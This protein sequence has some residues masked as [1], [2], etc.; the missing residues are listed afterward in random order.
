MIANDWARRMKNRITPFA[1]IGVIRGQF[2]PSASVIIAPLIGRGIDDSERSLAVGCMSGCSRWLI[3]LG[4]WACVA[5]GLSPAAEETRP[6]WPRP[7]APASSPVSPED[8]LKFFQLDPA[9][10]IELAAAEPQVIDP[11]AVR[12]DEDGRM[13]V[14]EM[15]DYPHGPVKGEPGKSQIKVLEDRDG[16]GRYET[17]TVFAD[18]LTFVTGLQPWKGGVFVT[19][20]GRVAYMKDTDG[21]G[22]ADLDETWFTGFA[23]ENS[24]LRANHPR[25]ALD[26]HIYVANGLRGGKVVNVRKKETK[27]IDISGMDFRFNPLT[28]D[29]EA[30]SG[31]S[32]FGLT[33]D[34]YGNRF[35]CTNRN[36]LV[37]V[38]LEQ[39]YL[40]QNPAV[41]VPSVV[42]D[43]AAAGE[44]SRLFPLTRNWTTSNL[45]AGQFTAAC[46]VEIYRGDALPKEFYGNAFTCDPTANL[47]HREIISPHGATFKSRPAYPDR[48]FLAST[49]E[50]FRPVN[51]TLGPEG[52]LYVVD[53]YRAVIEHPEFVPD[54]L[55]KRPDLMLGNDRGRIYRIVAKQASDRREPA[56]KQRPQ[57]SKAKSE[58]LVKLLEHE[59]AW[60]RETAQRLLVQRQDN[61][62]E[63]LLKQAMRMSQW[64]LAQIHAL[65]TLQG[66]SMCSIGVLLDAPRDNLR[67]TEQCLMVMER[68]LEQSIDLDKA[69]VLRLDRY[70]SGALGQSFDKHLS[71]QCQLSALF[72]SKSYFINAFFSIAGD[73]QSTDDPWPRRAV[74]LRS[75]GHESALLDHMFWH[76]SYGRLNDGQLR[77]FSEIAELLPATRAELAKRLRTDEELAE[78]IRDKEGFERARRVT[79]LGLATAFARRGM[80]FS[81]ECEALNDDMRA[82]LRTFT[83]ATEAVALDSAR[84]DDE[85]V[86][87]I[88]L[89]GHLG[90][91]ETL[92]LQIA[93]GEFPQ[94]ERRSAVVALATHLNVETWRKLATGI[95]QASPETRFTIVNAL[96]A[97]AESAQLLLDQIA[98]G[99]IKSPEIDR[100][101]VD[102]LLRYGDK[103]I[104][105]RA[106]KLLADAIPADRQKVLA[107]YQVVLK[108]PSEAKRGL[109]VFKKNCAACHR[110]GGIGVDV[111]PDISDSRVKTAEQLLTDIL[112]PNR[113]IDGNYI[114]YTLLTKDGRSLVGVIASETATGVTIK[115][116]EGKSVTLLRSEIEQMQSN[117]ISLMPEGVEKEINHQ[118]MADVISYIKNWR[119]LDGKTPLGR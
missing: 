72:H 85:R 109:E 21:D 24:Q 16:D 73:V 5:G 31:H 90:R 20:A 13:W 77:M 96:I 106:T 40:K 98:A 81:K 117:G 97:R 2:P 56:D 30:V 10:G 92:L 94:A 39:R 102:R 36:P 62:V 45:H 89:L 58:E 59:N 44:Q 69:T 75:R 66:T 34:D 86:E 12:F 51:L 19:L 6:S 119:Y 105:E 11:V 17:A 27:P 99:R 22:R 107:E 118:Q 80:L 84:N 82:K 8:S 28:G 41:A 67:V 42:Q 64:P 49:D 53:M 116:Q 113:A 37:H 114:S 1:F 103:A 50:W 76:A 9:C 15:R 65:R 111:A 63:A 93:L 79:L 26:N 57:L 47:V 115:Q 70:F 78:R 60:W 68:L 25:L 87:A 88:A 4:F 83:E 108:M 91:S 7:S 71:F 55:K 104:R 54:E 23:Q 14:V 112:Q 52:A 3:M 43:V 35:F 48:D 110:V 46:G 100:T 32:Q 38:V 61:S 74:V 95:P 101:H 33:F 18:Q 29:C